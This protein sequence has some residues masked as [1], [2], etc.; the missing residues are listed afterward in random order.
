MRW[1]FLVC[2]FLYLTVLATPVSAAGDANAAAGLLSE[3]CA[4]CHVI[5]GYQARFERADLNAPAFV[6]IARRPD[7]YPPDQVK[8]FLQRPHWP[9]TQ[10]ILSPS[11]IENIQAFLATLK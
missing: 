1:L 5:P 2:G 6:D 4:N 11:D 8:A 9:M 7:R 3:H 10:F